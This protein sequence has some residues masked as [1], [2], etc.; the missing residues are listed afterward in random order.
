MKLVVGVP[1]FRGTRRSRRLSELGK[2]R[3]AAAKGAR[4]NRE[5]AGAYGVGGRREGVGGAAARRQK[6]SR[7]RHKLCDVCRSG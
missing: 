2:M 7:G 4:T 5:A 3:T 1:A 6:F